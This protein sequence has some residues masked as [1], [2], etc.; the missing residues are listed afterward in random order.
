MTKSEELDVRVSNMMEL[1]K[2]KRESLGQLDRPR[3]STTCSLEL[4]GFDRINIQVE[5]D[6][7]LLLIAIGMLRRMCSDVK[8]IGE[9]L[10]IDSTPT[11]KNF[12][13]NAWCADLG[14]RVRMI[15][16]QAEQR[17]LAALEKQLYP[18]LSEE[19]RREMTLSEIEDQLVG[20]K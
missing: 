7:S 14:L 3:W 17:K 8:A 20:E 11:W 13:I 15:N 2:K 9:E 19:Q 12:E 5:K 1:V 4:P 10:G 6:T 16:K 18:L